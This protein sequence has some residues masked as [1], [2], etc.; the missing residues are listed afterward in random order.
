VPMKHQHATISS[1]AIPNRWC[2]DDSDVTL[3]D[4]FLTPIDAI[5]HC[6]ELVLIYLRGRGHFSRT[7]SEN[8]RM[9][10]KG[11]RTFQTVVPLAGLAISFAFAGVAKAQNKTAAK[12][13]RSEAD[14]TLQQ[15]RGDGEGSKTTLDRL[16]A[17]VDAG[18]PADPRWL[19][20]L[21]QTGQHAEVEQLAVKGII[22]FATRDY[23]VAGVQRARVEAFLASEKYDDAVVAA[24]GYY[25]VAPLKDTEKAVNLVAQCLEKMHEG[26]LTTARRF[27]SQQVEWSSATTK[28]VGTNAE[29]GDNVLASIKVPAEPFSPAAQAITIQDFENQ[30]AKGNLLLLAD[31]GA[32]ARKAFDAAEKLAATPRE[33]TEAIS[34]IARAIRAESGAIGPANAY[35]LQQQQ[36]AG[37]GAAESSS[38]E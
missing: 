29:L 37:A 12:P 30:M 27:K 21:L 3:F 11:I 18:V 13:P 22:N 23:S 25:N 36:K 35:I 6:H 2:G 31:N 4:D 5:S 8:G 28:P 15:L 32:G 10:T 17:M 14:Y 26:D 9:R 34:G 24:K 33:M 1:A 16:R 20:A 38:A 19:T 7:F